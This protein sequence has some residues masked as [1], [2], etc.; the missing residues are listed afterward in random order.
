MLCSTRYQ[1]VIPDMR[2]NLFQLNF[3]II[4]SSSTRGS[5]MNFRTSGSIWRWMSFEV[6]WSE[7]ATNQQGHFQ[8]NHRWWTSGLFHCVLLRLYASISRNILPPSSGLLILITN[9]V[10]IWWH[11]PSVLKISV[12]YWSASLFSPAYQLPIF[13]KLKHAWFDSVHCIFLLHSW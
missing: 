2:P 6:N 11:A 10:T 12:F 3:K 4:G 8:L 1:L 9:Y 7:R 5:N 13:S